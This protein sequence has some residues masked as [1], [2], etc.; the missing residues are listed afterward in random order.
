MINKSERW[1]LALLVV[2][3]SFYYMAETPP[4]GQG[5]LSLVAPHYAC[6]YATF[7][8]GTT[9]W[10]PLCYFMIMMMMI[11]FYGRHPMLYSLMMIM[12][13]SIIM[14]SCFHKM[15]MK[16]FNRVLFCLFATKMNSNEFMRLEWYVIG[17]RL[18]T[19]YFYVLGNDRDD[20]I[21]QQ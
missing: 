9:R 15:F 12:I 2:H 10:H 11:L 20:R 13:K 3:V 6:L 1:F 19:I 7:L 16:Y 18:M 8:L 17:F 21:S 5:K 4:S 14:N